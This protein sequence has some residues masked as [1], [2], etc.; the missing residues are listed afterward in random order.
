MMFTNKKIR[1]FLS[2]VIIF[3]MTVHIV[4]PHAHHNHEEQEEI[5]HSHSEHHHNPD[6]EHGHSHAHEQNGEKSTDL[7]SF[8]YPAEKHFHAFH[9]HEFVHTSKNRILELAEK[10]LPFLA[11]TNCLANQLQTTSKQPYRFVFFRRIVY[12]NPFIR[13]CSLRG[14]PQII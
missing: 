2:L 10:T 1:A 9:T 3:M 11:T 8:S 5:A 14:P 7:V 6:K 4:V 12:E 13:H